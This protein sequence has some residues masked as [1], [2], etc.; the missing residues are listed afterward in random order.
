MPKPVLAQI[1]LEGV[2]HLQV[3]N[4]VIEIRVVRRNRREGWADDAR[5]LAGQHGDAL[6][7]P[8]SSNAGDDGLAW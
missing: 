5:R 1:G 6:L 3:R 2:A 8:A 4:G 7:W